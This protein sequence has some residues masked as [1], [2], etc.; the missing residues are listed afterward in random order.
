MSSAVQESLILII[1]TLGGVMLFAVLIR[2]LLQ[3]AGADFY[4]PV[5]QS[6]V[7]ITQPLVAPLRRIIPGYRRFDFAALVL[8]LLIGCLA[9]TLIYL[10][11]SVPLPNIGNLISWAFVGMLSMILDIYFFGLLISIIASWIAPYSGN[12][13]LILI[14]QLLEPIQSRFRRVIPPL[15]GLDF[16]PIFIFLG[17]QVVQI[18][19][20]ATLANRLGVPGGAV[21]GI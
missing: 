17:I 6:L 14:H 21:I 19:V 11:A 10:V 7:K 4:N 3:A 5:S 20:V 18:M 15:G 2:F 8:A 13:I 1:R 12:P 9:T 16:S